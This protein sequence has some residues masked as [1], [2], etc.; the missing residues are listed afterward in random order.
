MPTRGYDEG[1]NV[2]S[3]PL[4]DLDIERTSSRV[5]NDVRAIRNKVWSRELEVYEKHFTEANYDEFLNSPTYT[6]L[7]GHV[8]KLKFSEADDLMNADRLMNTI[9]A[10]PVTRHIDIYDH[11]EGPGGSY[12]SVTMPNS[13]IQSSRA[14]GELEDLHRASFEFMGIFDF[15]R[16]LRARFGEDFELTGSCCLE[17]FPEI[18]KT[19]IRL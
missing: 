3:S 11:A 10:F 18:A 15:A 7:R 8:H 2:F 5:Y 14:D 12:G 19:N 9:R 17:W 1:V 6:W 16:A 4:P 13:T